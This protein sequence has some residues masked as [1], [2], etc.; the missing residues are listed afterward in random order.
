MTR[1]TLLGIWAHPDDETSASGASMARAV[2]EGADVHVV[3]ATR[4]EWGALGSG[5]LVLTR[6]ELPAVREAELRA[7]LAS[8]G[9]QNP[10]VLLGYEDGHLADAPEAEVVARLLEVMRRVR[11]SVVLTFGPHGI[12]RHPDHRALHRAATAAFLRYQEHAPDARLYYFALPAHVIEA[13][14]LELDGME[15]EPNIVVE[16]EGYWALKVAAL[17]SYRSQEDAQQ[18][19]GYLESGQWREE[20]FHQ[21]HPPLPAGTVLGSLWG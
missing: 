20:S 9:V 18:L 16:A 4:G 3:T 10:P 2:Q 7:V 15:A 1:R 17:R 21:A 6:E 12:S 5:G 11:P 13:Y 14:S 19:A 8:Y